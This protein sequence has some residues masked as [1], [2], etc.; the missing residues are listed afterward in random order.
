MHIPHPAPPAAARSQ[1]ACGCAR[2]P[3]Q[4][5]PPLCS[6]GGA[7]GCGGVPSG[8]WG[9]CRRRASLKRSELHPTPPGGGGRAPGGCAGALEA[10]ALRVWLGACCSGAKEGAMAALGAVAAVCRTRG[11]L[12]AVGVRFGVDDCAGYTCV[13]LAA[14]GCSPCPVGTAEVWRARGRR[15]R[16]RQHRPAFCW[17]ASEGFGPACADEHPT[18]EQRTSLALPSLPQPGLA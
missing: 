12:A 2:L 10:A 14:R 15:Q 8:R 7:P 17:C 1:G 13:Q 4:H 6:R 18:L 9:G 5:G 3:R 11:W 16:A